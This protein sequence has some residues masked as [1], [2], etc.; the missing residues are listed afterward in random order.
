MKNQ[1]KSCFSTTIIKS[2]WSNEQSITHEFLPL[3]GSSQISP[4]PVSPSV[5]QL[6][7]Q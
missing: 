5:A 6:K 2:S 3:Q 4:L 1:I 7:D